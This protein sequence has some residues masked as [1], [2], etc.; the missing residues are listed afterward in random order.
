M[1]TL[2]KL[3]LESSPLP[4]TLTGNMKKVGKA[5]LKEAASQRQSH[6]PM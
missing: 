1:N 4:T 5:V 3:F 6:I 2:R